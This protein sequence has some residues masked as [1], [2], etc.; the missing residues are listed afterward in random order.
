MSNELE[1]IKELC[2]IKPT[3]QDILN[4]LK[5]L[6]LKLIKEICEE[7]ITNHRLTAIEEMTKIIEI[8]NQKPVER[9]PN[10]VMINISLDELYTMTKEE[11]LAYF[12]QIKPTTQ[13][14]LSL[15]KTL[16]LTPKNESHKKLLELA[17]FEISETGRFR[18][19][20]SIKK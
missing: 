6:E 1:L 8:C 10:L 11:I 14:I 2:Q 20:A 16:E 12:Q 9:E 7:W 13:D 19:I 15:L 5:S 18:R 17:A 4:L 3:S